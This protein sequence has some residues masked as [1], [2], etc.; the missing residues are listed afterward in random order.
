MQREQGL[1]C[2]P[3]SVMHDRGPFEAARR[4]RDRS[5]VGSEPRLE[6]ISQRFGALGEKA[7]VV[8]CG[9]ELRA[10]LVGKRLLGGIEDLHEMASDARSGELG[11]PGR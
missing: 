4:V 11:E 7:V 6:L 1:F 3:V 2:R 10:P 9:K 8:L 5:L